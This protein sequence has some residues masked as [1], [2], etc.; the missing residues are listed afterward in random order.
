MRFVLVLHSHL[1]F[2]HHPEHE[3]FLEEE[4]LFQASTECYIPLIKMLERLCSDGFKL[5]LTV[6]VSPTLFEMFKSDLLQSRYINWLEKRIELSEKEIHMQRKTRFYRCATIYKS[7]FAQC[8]EFISSKD[9]LLNALGRLRSM[10]LNLITTSATHALLPLM[11]H[12]E[13]VFAQVKT[14]VDAF[15]E[16]WQ[17]PTEG[18]WLPECAYS[19]GFDRLLS[20]CG[21]KYTFLESHGITQAGGSVHRPLTSNGVCFF[22]RDPYCS[23]RVWSSKEGYPG[24]RVY[25]EYYR[26]IGYDREDEYIAPYLYKD[27]VRRGV[28]LK[29]HKITGNVPLD[30]KEPYSPDDALEQAKFDARDFVWGVI[31]HAGKSQVSNPIVVACYDAELFG[32][33]WFEGIY[34]LEEIFRFSKNMQQ[35]SFCQPAMCLEE[36]MNSEPAISSWGNS[37][38]FEMWLNQSNDWIYRHLHNAHEIMIEL[39]GKDHAHLNRAINQATRELLLAQSSDWPFMMSTGNHIPYANKRFSTHV[40]NFYRLVKQIKAKLVDDS[41]LFLLEKRSPIFKNV[42]YTYLKSDA[43]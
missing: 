31:N 13:A 37:G 38:Y 20:S 19:Q 26:D 1:P 27:K 29:F 17:K 33:W 36:A 15:A 8:R 3:E 30:Q 23:R 34:F 6:A 43:Y 21:I 14:G 32:H 40:S 5:D 42:N 16:T 24:N 28:G 10:G 12:R 4:W 35:I 2:V 9:A 18:L 39:A 11:V 22:G 41:F 25:R 7:L